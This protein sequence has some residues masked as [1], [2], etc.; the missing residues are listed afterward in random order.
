MKNHVRSLLFLAIVAVATPITAQTTVGV[1][2]FGYSNGVHPTFTFIFEGTDEKYVESY[3]RDE[4]KKISHEVSNKKEVVAAGALVPQISPDTVRILVKAEQRKGSPMLTA[5]VA[6][7]AREGYLGPD[8]DPGS[9]EGA[10]AFVQLHSTAIRRQL[11]QQELSDAEKGLARLRDDL[12][13]LKREKERAEAGVEKSKQRAAEAATDQE[14]AKAEAEELGPRIEAQRNEVAATPSEEATKALDR[15]LKDRSKAQDKERRAMDDERKMKK[16]AEDLEW[17][18]RRNV[19]DQERKSAEITRQ[20]E[21]VGSLREK[22]A[23]IR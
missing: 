17:E 1:G 5:H 23:G 14:H 13:M 12:A 20:E 22:L 15:M 3:W 19:E 11:A 2:S 6:I 8:S 9:F 4:L 10:K 18:I 16:K 7:L 21:L